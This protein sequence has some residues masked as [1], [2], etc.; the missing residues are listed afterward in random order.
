MR[1][2]LFLL[3]WLAFAQ[4]SFYPF[5]ID[6]DNLQGAPDFSFLNHP[7]TAAD[8]L[9]VRDGHF[10]RVGDDLAP[11]SADDERV[12]LFGVNLAFGA[13]F[14]SE[15]DSPRIAKRLRRMGVNLVRLHHLDTQPDRVPENAGSLLT[16][17]PYPSL[18]P[19]AVMRLRRFI[20]AL[21]QEGIYVNLNLKV[22]YLFRPA[23]DRIPAVTPF[24][25]QSKPLHMIHPRMIELQAE[26]TR[27]VLVA[28]GLGEDV[29]LGM[30]E[31]NN[32]S[33]LLYSWQTSQLD[34]HLAVE[35]KDEFARQWNHFLSRRYH[36]TDALRQAWAG[37]E[38][39]GS[40]LLGPEWRIENQSGE[41]ATLTRQDMDGVETL[42]VRHTASSRPIIL[43]QVG[44][45]VAEG[46][47]Y[48]AEVEIRA[49]LPTGVEQ[50]VYWDVK[51]DI[52]PWRTMTGR[53][54]SISSQW[55][56]FTMPV[57]A[58]FSMNGIGRFGLSIE[59]VTAPVQVRS[60]RLIQ[61]GRRGLADGETLEQANLTLPQETEASVE[62]R[63]NDY[64]LFL[65]GRDRAYLDEMLAAVRQ[66]ANP[67]VPVAGTQMNYGGLLNMD[68]HD[69]LDYQDAHFYVDHYNFPNV[70]WDNRDWR[71]RDASNVGS[72]AVPF[73]NMAASRQ[74]GRP[75]TVSEFNQN[76]PNTYGAEMDPALAAFARFQDWDAI[77]HFAY[78]HGRLWDAGAPSGFDMNGDWTKFPG[79]GQSAWLFRSGA[80][81][82]GSNPI[83]LPVSQHQRLRAGREKR[84]GNIP[85]F[86]TSV[87]GYDPFTPFVHPVRLVK[88]GE[89]DF[90]PEAKGHQ[91]PYK[92]D[93]SQL[94]FDRVNRRFL[95]HSPMAAGIYGFLGTNKV[96][97]GAIDVELAESSRGFAALTLT[98]LD[99]LPIEESRRLLLS[100][101]GA[102]FG[103]QPGTYPPRP[104]RMVNYQ[105]QSDWWTVEPDLSN[106]PSGQRSAAARP[107]WMEQVEMFFTLRT[108]A[109]SLTVYPL[110]G[111]GNR[112]GVLTGEN[113]VPVESGFRIHLQA[114]GQPPSPWYEI[115]T[116]P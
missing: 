115:S 29:A 66:T 25:D 108:R 87:A 9:F 107:T 77:M 34:R 24:P 75:F 12:Y 109:A 60:A 23:V 96:T 98:P 88:D 7:L 65:A 30:V 32:E 67:L 15:Q 63:A 64:L 52:N 45:S 97:A 47:Q 59:R 82:Q 74:A 79:F 20:D 93:N 4:P 49:E 104:Q 46:R 57:T 56:K 68:S 26:F 89:G 110:D 40:N 112:L 18:N 73:Q 36:T 72:G 70:A 6:Q 14:P 17:D 71:I 2:I 95:I 91:S 35:Y 5:Q 114:E 111:S 100:N 48:L 19:I 10:H 84:N 39:D 31:I 106:R 61:L 33:S 37:G 86:L 113:I 69:G 54:V 13:N 55:R 105:G 3:P 102:V 85:G 83:D 99:G 21:R 53:N 11:N 27:K 90:P 103:T 42:I 58:G 78:S 8:R 38:P 28:L 43:K 76:W 50:S 62:A 101:P 1:P 44:F 51:Q 16:T 116:E 81:A 41:P 80:I 92:S 22:G 94:T